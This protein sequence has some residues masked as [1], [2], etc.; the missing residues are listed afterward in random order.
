MI[1]KG[2]LNREKAF[3]VLTNGA[4]GS[5]LMKTL[6]TRLS[7]D[8]GNANFRLALMTKDMAYALK[9][10]EKRGVP[11]P[12]ASAA[13]ALFQQAVKAGLGDLD[14]AAIARGKEAKPQA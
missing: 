13:H 12:M 8:V 3:E 11:L 1:E 7:T 14:F 2:G 5:P 4:P 10:A 6:L 9:E